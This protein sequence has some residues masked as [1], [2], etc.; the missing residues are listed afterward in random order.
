M[1]V[2]LHNGASSIFSLSLSFSSLFPSLLSMSASS[3][4]GDVY[5]GKE[6]KYL[7]PLDN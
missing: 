6:K 5:C 7:V 1:R 3:L 4:I 2:D